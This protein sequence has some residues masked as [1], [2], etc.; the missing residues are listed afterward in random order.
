M[1][2]E[3]CCPGKKER[4]HKKRSVYTPTNEEK[5]RG[6]RRTPNKGNG[7]KGPSE[8]ELGKENREGGR[9]K[10]RE[11]RTEREER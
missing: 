10:G 8:G 3:I 6:G 9:A 11:I 1:E 5:R 4:P 2:E 7:L